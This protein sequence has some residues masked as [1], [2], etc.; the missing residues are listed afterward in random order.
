MAA[1]CLKDFEGAVEDV[2]GDDF[3]ADLG[4][5]LFGGFAP[6]L[7]FGGVGLD[8][9]ESALGHG[10]DGLFT[11]L[12]AG[13][14]DFLGGL[15]C[16]FE[17]GFAEVG[18]DFFPG[19]F[20]DDDGADEGGPI[21]F[22]HMGGAAVDLGFE[23]EDWGAGYGV[24]ESGFEGGDDIGGF[25]GDGGEADGA[26]DADDFGVTGPGEELLGFQVFGGA[27][28]VFG[29]EADPACVAPA[30]DDVAF[31]GEF[32]FEEG[33]EFLGD[34]IDFGE[35]PEA[36]GDILEAL[37]A[38]VDFCEA[39]DREHGGL[40]GVEVHKAD[41]FGFAAEFAVGID[42]QVDLIAGDFAPFIAERL[43]AFMVDGAGWGEGGEADFGGGPGGSEGEEGE[44]EGEGS[45]SGMVEDAGDCPLGGQFVLHERGPLLAGVG[46]GCQAGSGR[47]K[48]SSRCCNSQRA[49]CC[50]MR[51]MSRLSGS[52]SGLM[53]RAWLS[54]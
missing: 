19:F 11:F 42:E 38:G 32:F 43:E 33:L 47:R 54:S 9:L 15:L 44:G 53:L 10:V 41:D 24:D 51:F 12:A 3:T 8:D 46:V 16:G 28:G 7:E 40:D 45:E 23:G 5:G 31:G 36:H 18:G 48:K 49:R 2:G 6:F 25:E 1:V 20:A 30:E 52:S 29:E 14:A 39:D 4:V 35:V 22:D 50:I 17:H 34:V 21:D 37:D 26:V 13:G 27:D